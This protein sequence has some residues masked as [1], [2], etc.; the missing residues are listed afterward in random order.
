VPTRF[1]TGTVAQ[2]TPALMKSQTYTTQIPQAKILTSAMAGLAAAC[3]IMCGYAMQAQT[4]QFSYSFEDGPG[5]TTTNN[6]GDAIYPLP[7]NMLNSGAS[8]VDLHGGANSGIQNFGQSLNLS[9]NPLAG[10]L[11]GA[12]AE[13]QNSSALGAL[14]VVTNF[15][16]T[17]WIKMAAL[18]TNLSNQGSRIYNLM[19]TG[20]TDI[21]GTN[22]IGFQPQLGNP[23]PLFP[24]V[25]MRGVVGNTFITPAIYYDFPTNE[26]LFLALTYDTVS[27]NACL[28]YGTEASPAKLYVVKNIGPGTNF[29]FSGT[30]SFSLGDRPSKGRSFPGWIDEARF[31]TGAGNASFIETVRQSS[32]PVTIAGLVPDG[33]VLQSGTN[34]LSFTASSA[35]GINT[36]GI[37]VAV[38]GVDVSS[39]LIFGGTSTSRTVQYTN[40][41][42]NP[43]LT[44]ETNLN[45]VS[46]NIQVT[47]NGGI[48]TSNSYSYDAFAPTNFTWECEDYDFGGGQYIDN[49]VYTFSGPAPNTYNQEITNYVN[50]TDANDNGNNAGPSRVYRDSLENVETEYSIGAGGNG[51]Q[52]I[53]ELMRQKVLDAYALDPTIRDV[54]VGYFDGGTGS[55]LPNWMNYTKTYPTGSFNVYLRVADGGGTLIPSLDVVT[56][57]WGTS[58]QTTTNLGTFT[59]ANSG[60][61]D[62]FSWVPLRDASGN[63]AKVTLRGTNTIRLTAGSAGGGN[64]NFLMLT[65]ANTN[66]P[67][68]L[69]LYPNGTNMFQPSPTL[70]FTASSP[71]GVTINTNSIK[72]QLTVSNLLGQGFVTNLTATNGLTITGTITNRSVSAVLSSNDIYTAVISVTD[73]NGSSA[74]NTVT[75][76]T[77]SPVYTWEAP[78]Y[79]Y[80]GGQ[81]FDN[82]QTNDY[83]GLAAVAGVD[84]LTNGTDAGTAYAYRTAP[85]LGDQADGDSPVRLR[86]IV[87]GLPHYNVGW[88]D[89]GDWGNYTRT[90]PTGSFNLYM[91][92]AN[93]TSGLGDTLAK[94]TSGWGTPVQTT[95]NLGTFTIPG[96]GNWQGYEW[97]PLRD[98]GGNLIKL[99]LGGT[100]TLRVT[101]NTGGGGNVTF[102]MLLPANT[103][104]PS[105]FNVY[106]NGTN[107]F[108]STNTFS[109]NVQ[110]TV[111]VSSNSVV[112]TV[113]GTTVSNLVFSGSATNWNVSYPHLQPDT[114]YTVV[115]TVTDSNGNQ[116]TITSSFDTFGSANYTWEA[117]DFDYDGGQFFDNPQTNAYV[118][119]GAV[120]GV[121]SVQVNFAAAAP[122]AYRTNS[123]ALP[124]NSNGMSTE[125]N[126]DYP[127]SQYQGTGFTDYTMGYYSDGAWAN[128]TRHYPAG[129]Y[130]VYGRLASGGATPSEASLSEVT[131]GWGTATQTTNFLGLF[132]IPNT[133][134]ETYTFVPMRDGNGNL[135]SLTF[136]GSTNTL[137][138]AR[139]GTVGDGLFPDVNAN[140]LMLVPLFNIQASHS[141]A[142]VV[143]SFLTQTGFNYQVQY[144]T[145]LTDASWTSLG[146]PVAGNN[147]VESVNDPANGTTRFYRVQIQ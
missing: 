90:Y 93:G 17:V 74:G 145:H 144:K 108:Q 45:A 66:L 29:N 33:S 131:S 75:F 78:D 116:S 98:A 124:D 13:V 121:D 60:G 77:I 23:T 56:N 52:S 21:G 44:Q 94:V 81:Y 126:G 14:G 134:W 83:V 119:L 123:D 6:P 12:F 84:S 31:Y 35:S 28:Y 133:G 59:V 105:L 39:S 41:P 24:H 25:V 92:V 99:A 47:D 122:Y 67:A 91:R 8:P 85:G 72:V 50:L 102:Y 97:I 5:T 30:P 87:S 40:L 37:K 109:F 82:P 1:E 137:Q 76:D 138:L 61:W 143:V 7:L 42:V 95:T 19:G 49:P 57:G 10:N 112:V 32:T 70:S 38:N 139:P 129:T 65:P 9:T 79:D 36:S 4:L 80:G 100:N 54:N 27:G 136:N 71:S 106:P 51:G 16:A 104:L 128:Y 117:E 22:S 55:G 11:G 141:G 135:V 125:V 142:N 20:I 111:G 114:T 118:N 15:T 3:I 146:S 140:F 26:W 64:V 127:R 46:V 130:N 34:T 86:Y 120:A 88:Y 48:V 101:A 110:S 62:S 147:A 113:N 69:N 63:L 68:I 18:E 73:A 43:T 132:T 107:M 115:V 53:G 96:T 2:M 89:S 103:N 58:A